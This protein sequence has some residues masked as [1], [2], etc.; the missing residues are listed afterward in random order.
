MPPN[1]SLP[2]PASSP[3][4]AS[5]RLSLEE[6]W[7][8]PLCRQ[9][10]LEALV[11]TDAFACNFCSHILSA[12]IQ[13]QQVQVVDSSQP[14]AWAW[15][16]ARWR[17]LQHPDTRLTP[18]IWTAAGLLLLIP[19]GLIALASYLFPPLHPA[20]G[21]S[22]GEAWASLTFASHLLIVL[23]LLGEHYQVPIYVAAKVRWLQQRTRST[24]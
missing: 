21:L 20:P 24:T 1:F 4:P 9:G 14:L 8:C 3:D 15:T 2:S 11:L 23:W 13:R 6:H 12:D 22:F 18:L 17:S 5:Q 16:G 7:P 10:Q 19:S